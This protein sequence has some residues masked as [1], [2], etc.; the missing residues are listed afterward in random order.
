M[1]FLYEF[2]SNF[3]IETTLFIG[4]SFLKNN[5]NIKSIRIKNRQ[6]LVALIINPLLYSCI[7]NVDKVDFSK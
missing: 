7:T 2:K 6:S 5:K 1:H 3:K 4:Y